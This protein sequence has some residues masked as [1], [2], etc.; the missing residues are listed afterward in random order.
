VARD[1]AG[2]EID[3]IPD[4][5]CICVGRRARCRCFTSCPP[6]DMPKVVSLG[7]G[8]PRSGTRRCKEHKI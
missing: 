3:I 4:R 5:N 2:E 8:T 6:R 1:G 7:E